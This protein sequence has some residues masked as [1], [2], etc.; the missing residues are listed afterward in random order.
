VLADLGPSSCVQLA[1]NRWQW[2][3]MGTE[4]GSTSA[5]YS[6]LRESGL[7]ARTR[8]GL[9]AFLVGQAEGDPPFSGSATLAKYRK[10]Q[11]GLGLCLVPGSL[12]EPPQMVKGRRLDW[13]A[14]TEIDRVD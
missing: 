4:V 12:Q 9:L 1:Y 6:C 8:Q 7:P 10:L 14:G 3:G 5:V 13:E 11:R 2:S